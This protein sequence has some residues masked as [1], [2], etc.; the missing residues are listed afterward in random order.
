MAIA[1]LRSARRWTAA[2]K[3]ELSDEL[4]DNDYRDPG[5]GE[6]AYSVTE[7]EPTFDAA[8]FVRFGRDIFVQ[9][10]NVTNDFGIEW[11][12]RHLGDDYRVHELAVCDEHP[13][14]IDAT[15]VPLAPGR[16]LVN[17]HRLPELPPIFNGWEVLTAPEPC[18]PEDHCLYMTSPWIS[19]NVL[20]LDER[21]VVVEAGETRLIDALERWGFEPVPCEFRSFNSFG[22]S[23][24]CA[25]VDIRRRGVLQSYF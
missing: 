10:S 11:M 5:P 1:V 15:I 7:F 13:M 21:R 8:D 3:P 18:L 19:M 16:V 20:S 2:P 17:P 22:G 25:T 4:F 14:H 24:H 9:R 12:R 6:I 23:F